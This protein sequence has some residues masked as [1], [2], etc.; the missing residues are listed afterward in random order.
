MAQ[1]ADPAEVTRWIDDAIGQ[2][3][4]A[5]KSL[6][7]S[8]RETLRKKWEALTAKYQRVLGIYGDRGARPLGPVTAKEIE[9][10]LDT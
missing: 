8:N 7:A 4:A 1:T 2:A 6:E 9:Q 10:V 3:R 5:G